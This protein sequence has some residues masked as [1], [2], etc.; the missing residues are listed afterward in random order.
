MRIEDWPVCRTTEFMAAYHLDFAKAEPATLGVGSQ[1]NRQSAEVA[2]VWDSARRISDARIMVLKTHDRSWTA[3]GSV[4]VEG[5]P[6]LNL[7][8]LMPS[9]REVP[10][11]PAGAAPAPRLDA[12]VERTLWALASRLARAEAPRDLVLDAGE[13]VRVQASRDGFR[14]EGGRTVD[15]LRRTI[16]DALQSGR[17]LRYSL[18]ADPLRDPGPLH[19]VTSL[20]GLG[21]DDTDIV[22][23]ASSWPRS[24]P[25]GV[26]MADLGLAMA[27]VQRLQA[28]GCVDGS[29]LQILNR[30]GTAVLAVSRV[31]MAWR[32]SAPRPGV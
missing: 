20:F 15:D 32:V 21:H 19:A 31:D 26:R 22:H 17:G 5:R 8:L 28:A 30:S 16:G 6:G 23:A 2:A 18:T 9:L 13:L 1:P 12:P 27:I 4:L 7:G 14:L 3:A 25:P 10:D 24:G 11:L 29:R